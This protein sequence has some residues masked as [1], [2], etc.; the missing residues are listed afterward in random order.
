MA[1]FRKLK[2]FLKTSD[3]DLD[4]ER[5][6]QFCQDVPGVTTIGNAEPRKEFTVAGEIS[7]LRIVPRAGSPSLEATVN[8]G[9]GSLVVVWTGRRNIPGVAPGKRLVLTGRGAP[10]GAGGRLMVLN[11]R[12]ELL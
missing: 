11:P 12:Y 9:S 4:R 1:A 5:L 8:D 10:H 2:D 7:S 6:R 3:A